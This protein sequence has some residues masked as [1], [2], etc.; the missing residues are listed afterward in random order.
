M[1]WVIRKTLTEH[2]QTGRLS[3]GLL[4]LWCWWTIM[5][6]SSPWRHIHTMLSRLWHYVWLNIASFHIW[7]CYLNACCKI[8]HSWKKTA[9]RV[10]IVPGSFRRNGKRIRNV[11]LYYARLRFIWT[12]IQRGLRAISFAL[13]QA[14]RS[15]DS[16]SYIPILW[17]VHCSERFWASRSVNCLGSDDWMTSCHCLKT[18][19][20]KRH[21][22]PSYKRH[23]PCFKRRQKPRK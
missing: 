3:S 18:F 4:E 6:N 9:T 8:N 1:W 22:L 16:C 10:S 23:R 21:C 12:F 2:K 14:I 19:G 17:Q 20:E 5:M 7:T 11:G 13:D 15:F